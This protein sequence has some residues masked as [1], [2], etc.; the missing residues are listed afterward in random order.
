MVISSPET[1][2]RSWPGHL[3]TAPPSRL[4]WH[5]CE[6]LLQGM[7]DYHSWRTWKQGRASDMTC[8]ECINQFINPVPSL[9][10]LIILPVFLSPTGTSNTSPSPPTHTPFPLFTL[11]KRPAS[12]LHPR[13]SRH[14]HRRGD[15]PPRNQTL[16]PSSVQ[17]RVSLPRHLYVYTAF[18][19]QDNSP[20]CKSIDISQVACSA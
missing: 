12:C 5:R 4:F 18:D 1:A 20:R 6:A 3:D 17:S 7:G 19:S 9:G 13:I 2:D 8:G 16:N 15:F 14:R 11:N 10:S